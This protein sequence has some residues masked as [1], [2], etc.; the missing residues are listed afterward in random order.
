MQ[1]VRGRTWN[2]TFLS[3]TK[4]NWELQKG[5]LFCSCWVLVVSLCV[6]VF[7]RNGKEIMCFYNWPAFLYH[8][9][10]YFWSLDKER[11]TKR[12]NTILLPLGKSLC[13]FLK[14]KTNLYLLLLLKRWQR[15]GHTSSINI[16]QKDVGKPFCATLRKSQPLIMPNAKTKAVILWLLLTW[17]VQSFKLYPIP[18]LPEY[19]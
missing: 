17:M 16:K 10:K 14:K 12:L 13:I 6:F 2:M 9:R 18:M 19:G 8:I 5:F 3:I 1:F 15:L 4:R 11:V 7:T